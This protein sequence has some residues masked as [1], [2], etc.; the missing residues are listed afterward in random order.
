M[1]SFWNKFG[2]GKCFLTSQSNHWASHCW[3]FCKIHFSLHI[4]I[5]LRNGSLLQRVRK[6]NTSK[7][8]F[9]DFQSTHKAP[10]LLSF[11][12]FPICFKCWK[13]IEWLV[14]SSLATFL[15]SCKK[16][17]FDDALSWS[18]PISDGR[19]LHFSSSRLSSP[20]QNFLNH[21]CTVCSLTVLGQMCCW[22]CELSSLLYEVFWIRIRKLLKIAFCR[23]LP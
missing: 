14:L 6:Y 16:I 13:T 2:F 1:S 20:L 12:I 22:C 8:F 19:P 11:F 3:V 18:L 9:F 15:H 23:M 10:H 5:R 7:Q 4:T 17:S 21:H